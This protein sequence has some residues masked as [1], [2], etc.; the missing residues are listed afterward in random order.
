MSIGL[1]SIEQTFETRE[2]FT[3]AGINVKLIG[4]LKFVIIVK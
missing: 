1:T 3:N 4:T 2:F